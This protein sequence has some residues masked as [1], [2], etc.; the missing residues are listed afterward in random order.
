LIL[1]QALFQKGMLSFQVLKMQNT[2]LY[3]DWY[4]KNPGNRE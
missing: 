1:K 2:I 4:E 3:A